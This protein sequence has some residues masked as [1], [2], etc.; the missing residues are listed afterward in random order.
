[1]LIDESGVTFGPFENKDIF[2]IE[3]ITC[4]V[5]NAKAVEFVWIR[6]HKSLI[7]FVEAKSSFSKPENQGDFVKNLSDI[8]QKFIDS[9][10]ILLS[11]HCSRDQKVKERRPSEFDNIDWSTVKIHFRLVIPNFKKEWL[12][13]ISD[14]LRTYCKHALGA[15]H[16]PL[17][18]LS[19]LNKELA[20][21]QGLIAED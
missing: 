8:Y 12:P 10:F 17:I 21:E 14:A 16:I 20:I 2:R 18:N 11:I 6:N 9:L 5:P 7:V 1:M 15:F 3:D 13:P 4:F 19:V